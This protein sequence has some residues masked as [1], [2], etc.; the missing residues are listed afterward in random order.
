MARIN[1]VLTSR[2]FEHDGNNCLY[3]CSHGYIGICKGDYTSFYA[4][5]KAMKFSKKDAKNMI[6]A[7]QNYIDDKY[8]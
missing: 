8:E 7:L 4:E 1:E 5:R 3:L 2:A 6:V